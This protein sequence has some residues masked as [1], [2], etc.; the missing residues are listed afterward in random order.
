MIVAVAL[1]VTVVVAVGG[2][3]AY[4]A[5]TAGPDAPVYDTRAVFDAAPGVCAETVGYPNGE[6]AETCKVAFYFGAVNAWDED[7]QRWTTSEERDA[8]LRASQSLLMK[9]E[10]LTDLSVEQILSPA[11]LLSFYAGVLWME[12]DAPRA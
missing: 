9:R 12:K 6:K 4:R 1:V 8:G 11:F 10:R 3:M 5:A 7:E 2:F